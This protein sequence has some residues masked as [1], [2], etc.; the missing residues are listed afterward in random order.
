MNV[1]QILIIVIPK[2]IVQILLEAL[3]VLVNQ[4]FMEMVFL[5]MVIFL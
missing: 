1:P 5:V 3:L 4:V 2:Q